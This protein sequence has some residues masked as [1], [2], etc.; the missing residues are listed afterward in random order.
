MGD[1]AS[2]EDA[3]STEK[4][5]NFPSISISGHPCLVLKLT[6]ILA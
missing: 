6:D 3:P 5:D 4:L 2:S 1:E